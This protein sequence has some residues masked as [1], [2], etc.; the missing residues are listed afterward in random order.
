MVRKH[1]RR[2]FFD[3]LPVVARFANRQDGEMRKFM[4]HHLLE[5][6][7][8]LDVVAQRQASPAIR[9]TLPLLVAEKAPHQARGGAP[10]AWNC[11]CRHNATRFEP[12]TS[13][14][15]VTTVTPRS[16]SPLI[17]SRTRG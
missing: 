5:A 7:L 9:P 6:E 16:T 17:A 4:G 15:S 11:R 14:T 13:E 12:G 2:D 8:P 1:L 10:G 3:P